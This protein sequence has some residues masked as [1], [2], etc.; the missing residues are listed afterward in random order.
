MAEATEDLRITKRM[1]VKT[2]AGEAA[3]QIE[4][5]AARPESLRLSHSIRMGRVD[6]DQWSSD[7]CT[8][9]RK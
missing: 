9:A 3:R 2:Q 8:H 7:L 1:S 5:P 4:A 6:F